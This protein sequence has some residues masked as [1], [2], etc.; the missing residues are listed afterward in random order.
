[1][2]QDAMVVKEPVPHGRMPAAAQ[3]ASASFAQAS[4]LP[5]FVAEVR[6]SLAAWTPEELASPVFPAVRPYSVVHRVHDD[7]SMQ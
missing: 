4:E 5:A 7:V 1:M 6:R 3:V 2:C